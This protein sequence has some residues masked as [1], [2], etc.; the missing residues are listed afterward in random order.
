MFEVSAYDYEKLDANDS[1]ML[2]VSMLLF[3]IGMLGVGGRF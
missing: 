2:R 1:Y 3:M